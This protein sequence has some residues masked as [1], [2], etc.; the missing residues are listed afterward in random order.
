MRN[1]PASLSGYKLMIS[2]APAMKMRENKDGEMVPATTFDGVQQFVVALFAKR[3]PGPDGKPVG[4][5]EEI[6]VTLEVDPGE[7]FEEGMYVELIDATVSA[8][9][10]KDEQGN[11]RSGMSF[12]A[13]GLKPAGRGGLSSAA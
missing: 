9:A 13:A 6:R 5:G 11:V 3:R 2:E 1:I 4:K 12:K 10:M 7:G 8:W